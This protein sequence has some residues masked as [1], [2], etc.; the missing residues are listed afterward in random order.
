M[1]GN[2]LACFMLQAYLIEFFSQPLRNRHLLRPTKNRHP[3]RSAPQIWRI[4]ETLLREVEGP[5]RCS[6][7]DAL[8][9][10]LMK[11]LQEQLK[12]HK[13]VAMG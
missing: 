9:S 11:N 10:F 4:T 2:G 3:E 7:S 12:T 1:Q 13:R 5:R 6:L 8:W